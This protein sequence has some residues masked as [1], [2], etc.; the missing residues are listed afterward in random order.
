M[1]IQIMTKAFRFMRRWNILVAGVAL[2]LL[3]APSRANDFQ[4]FPTDFHLDGTP[5]HDRDAIMA[6]IANV[7]LDAGIVYDAD[8]NTDDIQVWNF[9]TQV[10]VGPIDVTATLDRI[11]LG[12]WMSAH[13][14]DGGF[15]N[16]HDG[17]LPNIP[18][19][20]DNYYME[21]VVWFA[22]DLD[23]GTYDTHDHPFDPSVVFPG[24][25][26]LLVGLGGEVYFS[27][28]HYGEGPSHLDAY[29][30]NVPGW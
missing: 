8:G 22:M 2:L 15:F 10:Y 18:R 13:P 24:P 20:G 5:F 3:A 21:F 12:Y 30:V 4:S 16:L 14:N 11:R 17:Q 23:A 28:D 9:Q 1:E 26:R 27:G 25:M 29:Y 19:M 7:P 6:A